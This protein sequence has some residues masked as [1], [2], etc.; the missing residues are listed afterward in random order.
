MDRLQ[1]DGA[2]IEYQVY[3]NGEP[4]LLIHPSLVADGLVRPLLARPELASR[5]QLVHYH[6]RGW[7]GS[8]LGSEPLTIARQASDA[9][10]LLRHL[11]VSTCHVAGH[12]IGGITAL[13]LALDA[14]EL[15]Q[16]LALLEPP[17]RFVPSGRESFERTNLP[18]LNA[19]RSGNKQQALDIFADAVFGP[20]WQSVVEKSV[21]GGVGLAARD[22]DTFIKEQPSLGEWQ[23]GPKEA[24]MIQK[25][26]LSV[27]GIRSAK[28]MKEGRQLL[29]S[30]FPQTELLDADATHLLQ[31]RDPEG[32]S[33]GLAE[34][35][36]RHAIA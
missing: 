27:L 14:P 20:N 17:L 26:V 23:F 2:V 11:G 31:M 22:L 9:A 5:Y 30:W 29:Q 21:P 8:T 24:A 28:F 16:S 33:H 1:A 35:F 19:Y 4:V 13:Q 7:M 18:M 3:G 6:R 36:S 12:S 15:V 25:P 32:V 34:F 10:I